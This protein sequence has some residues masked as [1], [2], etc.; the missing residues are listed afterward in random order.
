[1]PGVILGKGKVFFFLG[2]SRLICESDAVPGTVLRCVFLFVCLFVFLLFRAVLVAYRNSQA[3]GRI[4]TTAARLH[5]SHS[6][7]G[8]EPHLGPTPQLVAT[9]GP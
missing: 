1:M 7:A 4:R 8:S 9:L 6:N 2:Y 5:Y 3:R